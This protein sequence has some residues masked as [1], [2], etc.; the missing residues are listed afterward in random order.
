MRTALL[1]AVLTALPVVGVSSVVRAD[2]PPA[3]AAGVQSSADQ[4]FQEFQAIH[5]PQA[6]PARRTDPAYAAEH[7]KAIL[8]AATRRS[9]IARQFLEVAPQDIRS[10]QMLQAIV[11]GSLRAGEPQKGFATLD[12]FL[13]KHPDHPGKARLLMMRGQAAMMFRGLDGA[14]VEKAVLEAVEA[15]KQ[16][17]AASMMLASLAERMT[18]PA[19]KRQTL[20]RVIAEFPNSPGARQAEGALKVSAA[21]GKPF[22][23]AFTDAVTGKAIDMKDLRGKV[24]VIDFWATWCGPCIAEMPKMKQLYAEYKDKGVEFIGVSL[25]KPEAEGGLKALQAYVARENVTWLQYYQGNGW[26]SEFSKGWGINAIPRLF[27]VDAEGNLH[28]TEARGKLETLIPELLAKR[29]AKAGG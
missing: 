25:D 16:D 21:I 10:V 7:Q 4:L 5:L 24:V 3:A 13:A 8:E 9:E 22:E 11:V 29:D 23:L 1:A 19:R 15:N 14:M 17:P 12:A 6:D 28:S 26:Q 2:D 20:E 18:D 27:I